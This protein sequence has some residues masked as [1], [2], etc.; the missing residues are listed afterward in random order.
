M[1]L[2]PPLAGS[3]NRC[4]TLPNVCNGGACHVALADAAYDYCPTFVTTGAQ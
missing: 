3:D 1:T 2:P 4:A